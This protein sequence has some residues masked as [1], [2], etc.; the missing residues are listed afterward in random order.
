MRRYAIIGLV[1]LVPAATRGADLD[2][3]K[4][5]QGI[6]DQGAALFAKRDA[7]AMARTYTDE[8]R[9]V[10]VSKDKDTQEYKT[11]IREG[12]TAIHDLYRTM[13]EHSD[14]TITARNTVDFARRVAPDLLV[15][16]GSFEPNVGNG[17][18]YPFVQVRKKAGD[19]WLIMSLQLFISPQ[20]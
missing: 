12:R 14:A 20:S 8:A 4:Q 19:K 15:I 10:L 5:A 9:V 3:K 2:A 6:L 13:Y 11:D 17:P 7:E 1:L 18:A 16:Q